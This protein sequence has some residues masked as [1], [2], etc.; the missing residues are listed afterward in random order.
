MNEIYCCSFNTAQS[1]PA[2]EITTVL[3]LILSFRKRWCKVST[4][5]AVN[6]RGCLNTCQHGRFA[7]KYICCPTLAPLSSDAE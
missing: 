5:N 7:C 3:S 1:W 2:L 4:A 6:V